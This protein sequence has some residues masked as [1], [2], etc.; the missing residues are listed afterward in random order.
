M[1][2]KEIIEKFFISI[3]KYENPLN[4]PEDR[5]EIYRELVRYSINDL[6]SSVF[7]LTEKIAG[8]KWKK[9]IN[10]FILDCDLSSPYF[11]DLPLQLIEYINT[12]N[13]F[14]NEEY[15]KDLLKYEW[16]E[17]EIF[18]QDIPVE[19]SDF[20]WENIY[21]ISGSAKLAVF[22]YPVHHIAK[23]GISAFKN[24]KGRYNLI[25]YQNPESF[26]VE[27]IQLTDF[28]YEILDRLE[29][30]SLYEI[31]VSISKKHSIEFDLIADHLKKFF[32]VLIKNKIII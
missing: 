10:A 16:L 15:I 31:S 1:R 23:I 6:F 18:N 17:M 25:I 11:Q 2:Y 4:L 5:L 22:K 24:K 8:E 26:E 27:Y 7:P 29:E 9:V 32:Q 12:K 13:F 28:L 19:E 21:R 3:R 30:N 14:K 20:R